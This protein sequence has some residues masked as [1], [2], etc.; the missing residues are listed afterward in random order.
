M[1]SDTETNYP[2]GNPP[3]QQQ[4]KNK[5][6]RPSPYD[7]DVHPTWAWSMAME[8]KIVEEMAHEMGI[9]VS[10]FYN[11]QNAYP[12]FLDAVKIGKGPADARI[13]KALYQKALGYSTTERKKVFGL[14]GNGKPY[15]LRIEETEKTIVPDFM[16]IICWL[17]NRCPDKWRDRQDPAGIGVFIP[18]TLDMNEWIA[19]ADDAIR[20]DDQ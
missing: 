8:G 13:E 18:R 16:S 6:G 12:E 11:W 14:D 9:S 10:T 20:G 7:P 19:E 17:K 5:G 1:T 2:I 4:E 15:V 3:P